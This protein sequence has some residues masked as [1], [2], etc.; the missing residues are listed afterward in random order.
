MEALAK[1]PGVPKTINN[2]LHFYHYIVTSVGF[3]LILI[4]WPRK[5]TCINGNFVNVSCLTLWNLGDLQLPVVM[6]CTSH[7]T[8]IN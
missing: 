8:C 7:G 1:H 3:L 2:T 5:G 4:N 6:T